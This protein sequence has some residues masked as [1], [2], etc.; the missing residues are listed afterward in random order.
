MRRQEG[1]SRPGTPSTT[2]HHPHGGGGGGPRPSSDSACDCSPAAAAR[3]NAATEVAEAEREPRN[4]SCWD[5]ADV[6]GDTRAATLASA[7]R[8]LATA[9]R[10][11]EPTACHRP[12][13]GHTRQHRRR[14][15]GQGGVAST[16]PAP[17]SAA[18]ADSLLRGAT[19]GNISSP[20]LDIATSTVP[21][22]ARHSSARSARACTSFSN[23]SP[24]A[25]RSRLPSSTS[26]GPTPALPQ[27]CLAQGPHGRQDL[28]APHIMQQPATIG[29]P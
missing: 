22:S 14:Q 1:P 20:P 4:A 16:W 27:S 3:A 12:D 13:A 10:R 7:D 24:S 17:L 26:G 18:Q 21:S 8:G 29:L 19:A 5:P 28:R 23:T 9:N 15:R 2:G 11:C 25:R 6:K